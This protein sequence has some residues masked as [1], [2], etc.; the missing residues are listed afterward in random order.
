[1]NIGIIV[2]SQTGHTLLVGERIREKLQS[3]GHEVSLH[4]MQNLDIKDPEHN[5]K[6]VK[7]DLI[8]DASGYDAL[9]FGAWVQAFNL[10]P[11]FHLYLK[12]IPVFDTKNV[13]CFL[14]EQFPYKWMGGSFA[15]SQM[16]KLLNANGA[17]VKASGVINWSNKKREQQI[18]DLVALFRSQYDF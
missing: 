17:E 7:L 13:S 1:M 11:G 10:C 9:I 15:L 2:H 14:T 3:L 5:P 8:P 18:D 4:K 12:Q 16:K 6:N